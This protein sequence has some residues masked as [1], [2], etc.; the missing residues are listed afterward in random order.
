MTAGRPKKDFSCEHFEKLCRLQCTKM[1]IAGFF[2]CSEDTIENRCRE[3]YDANFSAVFNYFSA[4]G[5]ISLRRYQFQQA[6]KNAHIAIW[7]GKQH[8]GQKD[9]QEI[10][11]TTKGQSMRPVIN[12]TKKTEGGTQENEQSETTE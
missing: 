5:K 7:L 3:Y 11:H 4:D 6:E 8:L 1:E 9:K 12:F 10:D 2:E